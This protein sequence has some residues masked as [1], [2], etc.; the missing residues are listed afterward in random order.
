MY[1]KLFCAAICIY[2]K[3]IWLLLLCICV[4][5]FFLLFVPFESG[6][7]WSKKPQ[8]PSNYCKPLKWFAVERKDETESIKPNEKVS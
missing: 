3:V 8:P 4:D 2:Y 7:Q 1:E 5:T 6:Q